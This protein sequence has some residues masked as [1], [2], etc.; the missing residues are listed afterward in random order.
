MRIV[1]E[2]ATW[3]FGWEEQNSAGHLLWARDGAVAAGATPVEVAAAVADA[4][5]LEE[6][7]LNAWGTWY[8]E[9]VA[10]PRQLVG[11]NAEPSYSNV[12][13]AN[14]DK[15]DALL[16]HAIV[17]AEA[18]AASL[19]PALLSV[20]DV[21]AAEGD[22]G[23][24]AF[25]FEVTLAEPSSEVITVDFVTWDGSATAS[26]D[27]I[28][29]YGTLKFGK[30]RMMKTVTVKVRGDTLSEPDETFLLHLYNASGASIADDEGVGTIQNDD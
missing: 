10:S 7:I 8:R 4:L 6:E 24:T 25:T 21:T 2:R 22:S 5:E 19:T 29:S 12:E 3:R 30:G 1:V 14:L 28:P 17:N 26:T 16:Q 23:R 20:N 18:I 15:V 11:P 9:A 13:A 27:Y